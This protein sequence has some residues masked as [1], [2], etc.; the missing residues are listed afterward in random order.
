M[1]ITPFELQKYVEQHTSPEPA[2]LKELNRETYLK[3]IRPR[4][5]SGHFQGRVLSLFS[6]LINPK[7]VLEIG[8]FTGYSAICLAEGLHPE[9][10]IISIDNNEEL[11]DMIKLYIEKAGLQD[12][13]QFIF[14]DAR[15]VIATID[16]Q[17]ELVF[18][19]ADK[20]N[21]E[22]YYDMVIEKVP[23]GGLIIIDNVL[24]SGKV[25]DQDSFND[26][27]T[28][29]LADFNQK[30]NNDDRVENILFP[31][32]DGLMVVRKK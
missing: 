30:V 3:V 14:G 19:D 16:Q 21:Y 10:K 4:M 13:I 9:G 7:N 15:D 11:V 26:K 22:L 6:K 32:R 18:I 25:A 12:T 23:A 20:Q 29:A 5:I 31:L 1:E 24:W 27:T 28:A 2:L 8:T 17:F